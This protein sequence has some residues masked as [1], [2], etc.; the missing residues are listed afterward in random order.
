MIKQHVTK[1]EFIIC[2]YS[3]HKAINVTIKTSTNDRGPGLWKMNASIIKTDLFS[4][5]F[6]TYWAQNKNKK[7]DFEDPRK[8]REQTKCKIKNIAKEC[9]KVL[10]KRYKKEHDIEK[11]LNEPN[12]TIEREILLKQELKEIHDYKTEGAKIRSTIKWHEEGEK[13]TRYFFNLEKVR[14]K[15]KVWDEIKCSNGKISSDIDVILHE[16]CQFY[17]NLYTSEH[18]EKLCQYNLL[19]TIDKKISNE[20]KTYLEETVTEENLLSALKK[21]KN[22][23]SPGED[24]ICI[25]FYKE[26]WDDIKLEFVQMVDYIQTHNKLCQSQYKGVIT[27]LYK[28]GE[29][30]EIKNYRPI[31]VLNNDYKIIAKAFAEKLKSVQ[32]QIISEDQKRI[33]QG[34]KHQ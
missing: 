12:L 19:A 31:T 21:M 6:R 7:N 9:S 14:A 24:G 16:Q 2:P 4:R 25:E 10:N 30:N 18:T 33:C 26:F 27:L 8:W 15:Q 20:S 1:L 22:F 11:E 34:Q 29:R 13:S 5:T 3:D 23:K 17:K 28:Q 32:P